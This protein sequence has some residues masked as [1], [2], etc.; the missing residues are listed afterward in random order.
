MAAPTPTTNSST[1][2]TSLVVLKPPC[3]SSQSKTTP[4][5]TPSQT[6]A[7][8]GP[9]SVTGGSVAGKTDSIS[10]VQQALEPVNE[11]WELIE[12]SELPSEPSLWDIFVGEW[13]G[14]N[15]GYDPRD[16]EY[17]LWKKS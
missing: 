6:P 1:T 13:D 5:Q 15:P 10:E 12:R 7:Q 16:P 2:I 3:H 8:N 4:S 14:N 11:D 9:K 17:K